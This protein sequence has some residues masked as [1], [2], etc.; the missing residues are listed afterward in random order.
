[1]RRRHFLALLGATAAQWPSGANARG[2][3]LPVIGFL[4]SAS[5]RGLAQ[6]FAAFHSGLRT[7]GFVKGQ[8][9]AIQYRWAEGHYDR[10]PGLAADLVRQRVDVIAS[11]GGTVAAEAAMAAT[12]D[13]PIVF[14]AGLDPRQAGSRRADNVTGVSTNTPELLN[15]RLDLFRELVPGATIA[16]LLNPSSRQTA[17]IER[18]KSLSGPVLE[19]STAQDLE[20]AFAEAGAKR[21]AIL[22]SADPFFTINRNLIVALERKYRVPAAYPW[23]EYVSAGG[24][25]SYG[26]NLTTGY[27]LVGQYVGAA[28]KRRNLARRRA[29]V[30][31]A[32]LPVRSLEELRL[33][34]NRQAANGHG[35]QIPQSIRSQGELISNRPR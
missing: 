16:L 19:A 34:V 30:R 6:P 8:N 32:E 22:V 12:S 1:M 10:L 2:T 14:L 21:H 24:L 7:A 15:K 25:T 23:R 11:T 4:N 35:L 17:E 27:H 9:V 20:R 29:A 3:R 26:P 31:V 5:S 13:I 33:V 28:L 18:A